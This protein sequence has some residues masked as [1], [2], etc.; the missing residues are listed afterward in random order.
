MI[1][2][3]VISLS[4][5]THIRDAHERGHEGDADGIRDGWAWE[6]EDD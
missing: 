2:E 3:R 6:P 4:S 5:S 1:E